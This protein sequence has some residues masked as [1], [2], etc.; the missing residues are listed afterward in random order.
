[1]MVARP[2]NW[3]SK[4]AGPVV[5]EFSTQGERAKPDA[6]CVHSKSIKPKQGQ[7]RLTPMCFAGV[8]FPAAR[9]F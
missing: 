6:S 7:N 2:R 1:M 9:N 8:R 3:L 5:G 4:F